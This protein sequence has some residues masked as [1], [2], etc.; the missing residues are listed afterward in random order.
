MTHGAKK[1]ASPPKRFG[2]TDLSG[3][4]DSL[5][6]DTERREAERR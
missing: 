6:A 2:L 3:L 1:P 5:K 4:R